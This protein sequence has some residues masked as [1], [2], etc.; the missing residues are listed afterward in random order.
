MSHSGALEDPLTLRLH[1][2]QYV[3][4]YERGTKDRVFVTGVTERAVGEAD[5]HPLVRC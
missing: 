5:C 2:N 4:P 3:S 1:N